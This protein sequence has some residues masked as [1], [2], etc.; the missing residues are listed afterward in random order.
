MHGPA[1]PPASVS[2]GDDMTGTFRWV[3]KDWSRIVSSKHRS[4]RFVVGGFSWQ[5]LMFP[6]G[7]AVD[8][9]SLYLDAAEPDSLPAGWSQF[10]SFSLSLVCQDDETASLKKETQHH[11]D[12]RECDWGFTQF[13]ALDDLRDRS[14]G[15]LVDDTLIVV[16]ELTMRKDA[17]HYHYD[18]RK[19]TGFTGLKNQGATCYMNSLLQTLY[20]VP[21][22]RK[23]VYHMPTT[24]ADEMHD[25]I[26]LALQALFY[27]LQYA[28]GS[29]A[30]KDLTR[31]F[32]WD[33]YDSFLQHDVQ[34]LNRVLCE[35]LEEKMKG[36]SVEGTIQKLFEGHTVNYIECVN[37]DFKSERKEAYLDL[38]LD[39]KGCKDVYA[40]FDKYVETENLDGDNKYRAEGHGLQDAKKGVL[41]TKFPPVLQLQLKR[42]EYDFQ[43]DAMVKIND[44]YEFPERLD[45]DAG[46]GKYLSPD[47]DRGVRNVYVLHSVLVH[48]GGVNGGHYYAFIRPNLTGQWFKFDDERVT[49]EEAARALDEQYG[50]DAGEEDKLRRGLTPGIRPSRFSNAY[51]LVYV[52]ESDEAQILCDATE[53]DIQEHLLS[54]L[55][56]EKAEKERRRKEKEEAHLFTTIK[57]ATA[58]AMRAQIDEGA[59]HFDLVDFDACASFRVPKQTTFEEFRELVA[60]KLGVAPTKQR[61]WLFVRRQNKTFRPNAALRPG[62]CANKTVEELHSVFASTS[63]KGALPPDLKLFLECVSDEELAENP[64][65]EVPEDPDRFPAAKAS[66]GGRPRYA[67][68]LPSRAALLFFK[69]FD[70]R[71]ERIRFLGHVFVDEESTMHREWGRVIGELARP[72]LGELG[73][74]VD[75]SAPGRDVALYEEIKDDPVYVEKLD[76]R[77][78]IKVKLQLGHGDV[79]IVQPVVS[80]AALKSRE[81]RFES[82]VEFMQHVKMRQRVKFRDVSNAKE[83][84][85]ALDL[86]KDMGYDAVCSALAAALGPEKCEDPTRLRLT[87]HNAYNNAPKF[88]SI[89]YRGADTL[90]Q[91]L[92]PAHGASASDVLYFEVLDMPLPDLER[93]KSLKISFHGR[94]T[95]MTDQVTIRMPRDATVGE[96]LEELRGMLGE[97]RGLRA[98]AKLR[99]LETYASK[100]YKIV[101]R[102]AQIDTIDDQYWTL[103]AE[104]VTEDEEGVPD[105]SSAPNVGSSSFLTARAGDDKTGDRMIHVYHFYREKAASAGRTDAGAPGDGDRRASADNNKFQGVKNFGDP[106][107]LRV[108][109]DEPLR[110]VRARVQKK[111]GVEDAEFAKWKWAYHSLGRM[112]ELADDEAVAE[113]FVHK[114]AYGPYENYLGAEHEDKNPRKTAA[115]QNRQGAYPEARA[116]AITIRG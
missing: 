55:K 103:R 90:T 50:E 43:R 19:E 96:A 72:L 83:D 36:T 108:G 64:P 60:A 39:V 51:M 101:S 67:P 114:N 18:S 66:P 7:N 91:M 37:V 48:S 4:E 46:D 33:A 109:A 44:R 3:I 71:S 61:Y 82:C 69:F 94:D 59:V 113:K 95:K 27:K 8:H 35:N 75:A 58:E 6:R 104:E 25:S 52:R 97:K 17:S 10:A 89:A 2:S 54:R 98:D 30:T 29:V 34:E 100:I 5:L 23:A 16:C 20:H 68:E 74:P 12:G 32:G 65:I 62:Q 15:Y 84:V 22:F 86:Q 77:G 26:P 56:K 28:E 31:S 111:L 70:P 45:L 49:K 116:T 106:F 11:F 99:L 1:P 93:L 115:A 13:V 78:S 42:F 102:D 14:N 63:A 41:F 38:Q 73:V 105:V 53:S 76:W 24:E 92:G 80:S 21:Y 81:V 47:A 112:E 9:L 87:S 107:L 85:L 57:V 40:S 79:V 110:S 88:P